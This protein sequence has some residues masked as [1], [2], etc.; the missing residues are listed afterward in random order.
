MKFNKLLKPLIKSAIVIGKVVN[1]KVKTL[2][3]HIDPFEDCTKGFYSHDR[4]NLRTEGINDDDT[5]NL[6]Q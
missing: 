6:D 4:P 2:E 3:V 5:A 1:K